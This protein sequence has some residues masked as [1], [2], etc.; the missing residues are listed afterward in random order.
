MRTA[1]PEPSGGGSGCVQERS[2]RRGQGCT[3]NRSGGGGVSVRRRCTLSP[4]TQREPGGCWR[5]ALR[6]PGRPFWSVELPCCPLA[7]RAR[8]PWSTSRT[9]AKEELGRTDRPAVLWGVG[10]RRRCVAGARRTWGPTGP[11]LADGVLGSWDVVTGL[12]GSACGGE[13]RPEGEKRGDELE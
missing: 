10:R 12:F 9:G 4:P 5:A 13:R 8:G 3:G 6:D 7:W 11:D 1:R 2:R